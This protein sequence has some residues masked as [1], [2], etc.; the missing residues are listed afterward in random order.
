MSPRLKLSLTLSAMLV[1]V[2]VALGIAINAAV[3]QST[4]AS[5]ETALE[6]KAT[7]L[8]ASNPSASVPLAFADDSQD[9]EHSVP[10]NAV[11]NSVQLFEKVCSL[12]NIGRI[13]RSAIVRGD[14]LPMSEAGLSALVQGKPWSEITN[15][16]AEP[17]LIYS[18]PI[19]T[20][21]RV[22]GVAQVG[23]SYAAQLQTL[24][25][26]Q[27]ALL[28]GGGAAAL[29][30]FGLTWGL[31]GLL[32]SPTFKALRTANEHV[33]HAESQLHSQREFMADVSH[34]LRAPL[35]TVRGNL[36]LLKRAPL[37]DDD[38]KAV[39]HDAV[40]EVERMSRMVNELLL[41]SRAGSQRALCAQ[42]ILLTELAQATCRK[43]SALLRGRSM[44]CDLEPD[45]CVCGDVDAIN[46]VLL[47]LLDNAI[48]FTP[49]GG[50]IAL[51]LRADATHAHLTVA[52]TGV[53]I[54]SEALPHI[55]DRFFRASERCTGHGLGLAIA[56]SLVETHGGTI[57]VESTLG[58]G[59]AFTV[60]LP[61]T[62]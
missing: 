25:D 33:Q 18:Q 44:T 38:R 46:Q 51:R 58:Q 29:L 6:K 32:L 36:G 43:I 31:S 55:F 53:G 28:M 45:V 23:K 5:L 50:R 20:N 47:I 12:D 59:S 39:L 10:T 19:K 27:R 1:V 21:N 22:V 4:R 37:N 17:V 34:E 62:R 52:D 35:T 40:D 54:A 26:M 2:L 49:A 48:K 61:L 60:S 11:L 57:D 42:P 3:A 56:K 14:A 8:V 9:P 16:E 24:S 15:I 13:M 30:V 7:A 41:L